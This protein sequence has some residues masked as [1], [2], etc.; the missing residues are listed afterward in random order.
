MTTPAP[1]P[2]TPPERIL[3][4]EPGWWWCQPY[5]CC[6]PEIREVW[7]SSMEGRG[8]VFFREIDPPSDSEQV[9][10][11]DDVTWLAPIPT[12]EELSAM[13]AQL[14]AGQA[15]ADSLR[16]VDASWAAGGPISPI[17]TLAQCDAESAL[18]AAFPP[19]G[20]AR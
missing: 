19:A 7:L 18:L 8:L 10:P 6:E 9:G 16:A 5:R 17:L 4:K 15:L 1:T 2:D 11:G 12:P 14:A 20:G 3:P 13:A